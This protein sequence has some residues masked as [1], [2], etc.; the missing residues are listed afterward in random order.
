MTMAKLEYLV[1]GYETQADPGENVSH[2][3]M[4]TR[5]N[6]DEVI[7]PPNPLMEYLNELGTN[8]WEIISWDFDRGIIVFKRQ[9]IEDEHKEVPRL[10]KHPSH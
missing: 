5:L 1:V 2:N 6:L 9:L 8:E 7:D 3:Q 4:V 10:R